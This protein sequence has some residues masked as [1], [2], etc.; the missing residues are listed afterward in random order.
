[1]AYV[2][3]SYLVDPLPFELEAVAP[4]GII[5]INDGKVTAV[6]KFRLMWKHFE[7]FQLRVL[8]KWYQENDDGE[9]LKNWYPTLPAFYPDKLQRFSIS[10]VS[11]NP[12]IEES[13]KCSFNNDANILGGD[14]ETVYVTSQPI[15]DLISKEQLEG[16]YYSV[17]EGAAQFGDR[18]VV[19]EVLYS[20]PDWD[21]NSEH[22]DGILRN[23]GI[24]SE[25]NPSYEVYTVP[26]RS[27]VF[28]DM[29]K[30]TTE[31]E[32]VDRAL[33][34]DTK[35]YIIV[36]KGDV[37]VHW[38]NVPVSL[39]CRIHSHLDNYR[40]KVNHE[41]WGSIL[42]C[43][44]IS[45]AESTTNDECQFFPPETLMFVDYEEDLSRRTYGFSNQYLG[46]DMNT[47]TLKLYFKF[48]KIPELVPENIGNEQSGSSSAEGLD[49]DLVADSGIFYGWNHMPTDHSTDGAAVTRW[50]RVKQ[51]VGGQEKDLFERVDFL[52][53]MNP[54]IYPE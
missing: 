48:K 13:D 14:D 5:N 11:V 32:T 50:M 21:C 16:F 54:S 51:E 49:P 38:S 22:L 19:C 46:R 31:G 35:A 37:I 7:E 26:S 17:D 45:D 1:M 18:Y 41:E 47:T 36:P 4:S 2:V 23:T 6:R 25:I 8:G 12:V 9:F 42:Y 20:E 53:I 29:E 27:L 30:V 34:D 3:Q 44:R 52:N 40:G 10:A 28:S 24:R 15:T 43:G 33:K 39:L